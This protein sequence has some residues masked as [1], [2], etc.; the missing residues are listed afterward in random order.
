M[1]YFEERAGNFCGITYTD[2]YVDSDISQEC[3]ANDCGSTNNPFKTITKAME[4][5]I[6]SSDNPINI[7][8]DGGTYSPE[9]GEIF[10]LIL[11]DYVSISGDYAS[12]GPESNEAVVDAMQTAGIGVA[13]HYNALHLQPFYKKEFRSR[14]ETYPIA[15]S[16]SNRVLSLPLYPRMSVQNVEHVIGVVTDLVFSHRR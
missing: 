11:L 9:T 4:M 6:P 13:V 3:E 16:Y 8:I 5:I 7:N 12:S 1:S 10:P 14:L 15:T 2:V